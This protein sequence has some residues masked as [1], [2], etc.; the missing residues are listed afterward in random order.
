MIDDILA[1]WAPEIMKHP[2][3]R[4]LDQAQVYQIDD[5]R[6][7]CMTTGRWAGPGAPWTSSLDSM[8]S[9]S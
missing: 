6:A 2:V 9:P 1:C 7:R 4:Y 8:E 5:Y 3:L